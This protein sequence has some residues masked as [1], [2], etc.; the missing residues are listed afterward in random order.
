LERIAREIRVKSVLAARGKGQAYI[1]QALQ[2]AELLSC[3]FFDELRWG[4]DLVDDDSRDRFLLS[5][6]HYAL[7]FYGMLAARGML[8]DEQLG[9]Y[10]QDGN[11]LTLGAEPGLVPGVEFAGGSLGQGL[12]VASGLAWGLSYR[13][14]TARVF[15]YM[16]D[17]EIQEGSTW[18]AAMFAGDRGLSNLTTIVDVNRTQADGKLVLEIEPLAK[19]FESFGWWTTEVDGNDIR[20]VLGAFAEARRVDDDRPRAVIAHTRLGHGSPTI[21]GRPNAHFVRVG[22]D[23]WDAV[24]NE[25]EESE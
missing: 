8:T 4:P 17:G 15:N 14:N 10:G 23:E 1:G 2:S 3:L 22:A 13:K 16:S 19:K 25:V 18:E 20:E 5:V 11:M 24:A 9:G 7:A 21:Q 6:G 12:G